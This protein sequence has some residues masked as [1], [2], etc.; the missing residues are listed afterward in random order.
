MTW[1]W[2]AQLTAK[3]SGAFLKTAEMRLMSLIFGWRLSD[4]VLARLS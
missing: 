2:D 4:V 1:L 3:S